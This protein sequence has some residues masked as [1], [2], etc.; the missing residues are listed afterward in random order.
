MQPCH[1]ASHAF[2]GAPEARVGVF[3]TRREEGN[4]SRGTNI[5]GGLIGK[6]KTILE[7]T[8][9]NFA[10]RSATSGVRT[11]DLPVSCRSR[12]Q[13]TQRDMPEPVGR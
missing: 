12:D 9:S 6:E 7:A 10:I 2:H 4:P 5:T 11:S 13:L 3:T 1:Y 8:S